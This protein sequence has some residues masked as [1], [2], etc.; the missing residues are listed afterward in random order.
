MESAEGCHTE[1]SAAEGREPPMVVLERFRRTFRDNRCELEPGRDE[2]AEFPPIYWPLAL[3]V[4]PHYPFIP[5]DNQD[6][7]N[8]VKKIKSATLPRAL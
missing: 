1:T 5:A 4:S 3:R 7:D 2:P 6:T 8:G